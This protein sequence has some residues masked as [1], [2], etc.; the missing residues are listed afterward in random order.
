MTFLTPWLRKAFFL[1]AFPLCLGL[2]SPTLL[3]ADELPDLGESSGVDLPWQTERKLGQTLFNDIRWNSPD[4]LDD[5]EVETYLNTLGRRLGN[6]S[7]D[8]SIPFMF[9]GID[10]LTVNAFATFG[11]YIGVNT[12]LLLSAQSESELAGVLAHEISHTAQRHLARQISQSK[13]S[14]TA[15]LLAMAAS[16]L[17][18]RSN[19]Q[20]GIAGVIGA[21]AGAMQSQLGFSRD[22][23]READRIG[24]QI[25]EKSG[26]DPRGMSHFF[27]RLQ[28]S[29]RLYE[30]NAPVYLR[31]HPLTI[32]RI[33]DMQNRESK[34]SS[35]DLSDS[36]EFHLI[37]AKLLAM[38]GTPD[39]GVK[40]L[41]NK[42]ASDPPMP[43]ASYYGLAVA[44]F[45]AKNW[46]DAE[47]ALSEA[48]T[49]KIQSP[50]LDRLFAEIRLAQ[51]D[52][53][54]ALKAY[55]AALVKNPKNPALVYGHI[56]ALLR[57]NRNAEA[58]AQAEQRTRQQPSD[59][60]AWRLLAK[61]AAALERKTAEH[62]AQGE[63]YAL[64]GKTVAALE[65]MEIGQRA[66]DGNFYEMSALDARLHE[67]RRLVLEERRDRQQGLR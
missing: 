17:A 64:Q 4:Y 33:S 32:E 27:E 52:T 1:S 12:G 24:I 34:L 18:A 25:L 55:T 62:R 5:P 58:H 35:R 57:L 60:N 7:P 6:A 45:R 49:H 16:I 63:F 67:L 3:R 42:L 22:Y 36:P 66:A 54:G 41:E 37:K 19:S 53:S 26:L 30:N 56:E 21:Q 65:Q 38:K 46:K 50:L 20:A 9:F 10:D 48:R 28:K 31:T 47:K 44:Q 14:S 29:T 2:I 11:G 43:G 8:P 51:N 39:E 59:A 40:A 13:Q 61:S 23:E 15:M